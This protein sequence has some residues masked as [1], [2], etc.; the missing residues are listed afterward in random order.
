M[1]EEFPGV[2]FSEKA[3]GLHFQVRVQPRS[4]RSGICGVY[5]GVLK[6][7][8]HAAPVD[9]AANK[10][11]CRILAKLFGIPLS[12]LSVAT[13]RSSRNKIVRVEGV[14]AAAASRILE[15]EVGER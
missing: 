6:I 4:S 1:V 10:E 13:G 7:A 12:R 11:C 2:R 8:L 3:N 15:R 9:D 5:E 14:S